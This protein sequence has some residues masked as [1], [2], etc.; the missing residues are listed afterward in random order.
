[1]LLIMRSVSE[2]PAGEL[3]FREWYAE[4]WRARLQVSV[5]ATCISSLTNQMPLFVTPKG[6]Q[7]PAVCDASA[8]RE[9]L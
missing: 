8:T 2:L 1:M 4:A 9:G 3:V 7:P 6:V 5:L